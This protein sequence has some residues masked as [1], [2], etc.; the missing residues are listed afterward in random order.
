MVFKPIAFK[1]GNDDLAEGMAAILSTKDTE[2]PV[3]A[4]GRIPSE[5]DIGQ[6][7]RNHTLRQTVRRYGP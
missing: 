6:A 7:G 5:G 1:G 3:P 4:V 2:H